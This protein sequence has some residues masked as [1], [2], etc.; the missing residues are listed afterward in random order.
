[1][2]SPV[3]SK[4]SILSSSFG[5]AVLTSAT[6]RTRAVGEAGVAG[7]GAG[8]TALAS[9]NCLEMSVKSSEICFKTMRSWSIRCVSSS[10]VGFFSLIQSPAYTTSWYGASI[11]VLSSTHRYEKIK[12]PFQSN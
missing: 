10:W 12:E 2:Y 3:S 6:V 9:F 5:N 11:F 7:A 8:A 1:M 4:N